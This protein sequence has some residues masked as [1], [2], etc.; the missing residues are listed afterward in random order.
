VTIPERFREVTTWKGPLDGERLDALM[1][2][3]AARI[4]ELGRPEQDAPV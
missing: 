4:L 1:A 3:Y 2:G